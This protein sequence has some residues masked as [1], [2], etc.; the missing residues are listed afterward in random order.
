MSVFGL[1][2]MLLQTVPV[3]VSIILTEK[4]LKANF[5]DRGERTEE[6]IA[7]EQQKLREK[8]AKKEKK[9]K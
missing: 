3:I 1:I 4:S 9:S 8:A 5:N 7:A 6:S 2:I